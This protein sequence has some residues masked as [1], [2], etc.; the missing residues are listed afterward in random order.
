MDDERGSGQTM[1]IAADEYRALVER[2]RKLEEEVRRLRKRLE[3]ADAARGFGEGRVQYRV[4]ED[5]LSLTEEPRPRPSE[6]QVDMLI[7]ESVLFATNM[8]VQDLKVELAV[9]L[10][11]QDKLSFGKARELAG[12]NVWDFMHLLGSRGVPIHYDV[13]EYEEDLATLE[14]LR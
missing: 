1:V 7:P 10:F 5:D 3:S 11:A 14:K 8:S 12:M 2:V 13:D 9:H 4:R 6:R